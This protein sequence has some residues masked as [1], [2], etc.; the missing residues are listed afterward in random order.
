MWQAID[1]SFLSPS[2]HES[3]RSRK[4]ALERFRRE[5]FGDGLPMPTV[6]QPSERERLLAQ[7]EQLRDLAA[8]GMKP[9]TYNKQA[10]LLEMKAASLT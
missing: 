9:R 1:H 4:V 10:Q 7:A 8:R 6:P 5:L 2:G 3:K